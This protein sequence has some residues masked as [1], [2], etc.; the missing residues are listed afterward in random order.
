MCPTRWA[1]WPVSSSR[2]SAARASRSR[3]SIWACSSSRVRSETFRSSVSFWPAA[4]GSSS[5]VWSRFLMRSTT[6]DGVHRLGEEVLGAHRQ[7]SLPGLRRDVRREDQ[8]RDEVVGR[9]AALQLLHDREPVQARACGGRGGGC[10]A[11]APYTGPGTA[12]GPSC[13]RCSRNPSRWR[14]RSRSRT[15]AG[16]S[17]T[18]RTFASRYSSSN[19]VPQLSRTRPRPA[20][21]PGRPGA[22]AGTPGHPPPG[23]AAPGCWSRPR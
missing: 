6:S 2:Y 19:I 1:W 17:S 21:T 14:I 5:R 22:W 8:D 11:G 16:S 9:D 18:I 23:A 20:G 12:A 3:I 10:R 4:G 7:R 13:S 15:L